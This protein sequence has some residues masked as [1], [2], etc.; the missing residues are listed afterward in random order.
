MN[1]EIIYQYIKKTKELQ[2]TKNG[3]IWRH[4]QRLGCHRT[5]FNIVPKRVDQLMRNGYLT[6]R[7]GINGKT[8]LTGSHRLVY[9]VF[10]G[11]IPFNME[12]NHKNGII[13]DNRPENLEIV[14]PS[15]NQY[16]SCKILGTGIIG[17]CGEQNVTSRLTNQVVREI[18]TRAANG[19][20]QKDLA[21][22]FQV[23]RPHLSDIVNR[24]RWQHI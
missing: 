12:I 2:V 24:K 17:L 18:R 14:T 19:E 20:Q 3:E 13:D 9:R 11:L 10:Y 5:L 21:S 15:Q 1:E 4:K 22:E 7:V 16:H 23:C 8:L 6:I